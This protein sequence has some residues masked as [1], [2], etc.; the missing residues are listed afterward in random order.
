MLH[1]CTHTES[2]DNNPLSSSN[3]KYGLKIKIMNIGK[4][5]GTADPNDH[6]TNNKSAMTSNM[7]QCHVFVLSMTLIR[8]HKLVQ[9]ANN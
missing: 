3:L 9:Q 4:Y 7:H 1:Q 6:T 8:V 5:E 2:E